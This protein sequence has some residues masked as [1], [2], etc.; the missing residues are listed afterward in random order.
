MRQRGRGRPRRAIPEISVPDVPADRETE[1]A[2]GLVNSPIPPPPTGPATPAAPAPGVMIVEQMAQ[3]LASAMCQGREPW[4]PHRP[5][6]ERVQKL[7]AKPF[8]GRG[9]PVSALDWLDKVTEIYRVVECTDDQ[10]VTFSGFLLKGRAKDW[11]H[12]LERRF[13][14]GVTWE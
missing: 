7:G 1:H 4:E 3:I 11:W 10:R 13:P 12:A 9:D 6:I 14:G 5:S 8:N 2:T